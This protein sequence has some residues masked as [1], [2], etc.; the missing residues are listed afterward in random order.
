MAKKDNLKKA[1]AEGTFLKGTFV[2]I[3]DPAVLEI[4]GAAGLDFAIVDLEHGSYG[5]KSAEE[6][7]R[8]AELAGISPII[9]VRKNEA[10][11]ISKA[12]DIG[13]TGVQVPQVSTGA[14]ASKVVESALFYPGGERGVCCYVRSAGY[15]H[16]PKK[17]YL[18]SENQKSLV[19][20]Q[21]EGQKGLQNI[22]EIMG[23]EGIDV[24]FIGPYD[25]SQ[26]LGVPGEIEHPLVLKE[27]EGI[28]RRAQGAGLSAGT[29]VENT[30]T[31]KK[32][33]A[34]GVS[35]LVYSIDVGILYRSYK[36]V[37]G[38]IDSLRRY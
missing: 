28:A 8:A 18:G 6:L 25:L 2:R 24:I 27:M 1:L 35:Y 31:A 38:A 37:N 5:Y 32:W 3:N 19:V 16:R 29:F 33:I 17:D 14:E 22:D 34:M 15:S 12:L 30:L 11:L 13:A 7:V 21:I 26:S 36:M 23:V 20:V 9:R 4:I 10:S